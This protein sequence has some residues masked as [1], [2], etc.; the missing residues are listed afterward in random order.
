MDESM[1]ARE[2]RV[3]VE[4]YLDLRKRGHSRDTAAV[5]LSAST[6]FPLLTTA[7][8]GGK[9][10]VC[11]SNLDNWKR[12]LRG[13]HS[14]RRCWYHRSTI[15]LPGGGTF[16]SAFFCLYM[17]P[18][19]LSTMEA[20]RSAATLARPGEVPTLQQCKHVVTKRVD[21]VLKAL[22]R[23]ETLPGIQVDTEPPAETSHG[24]RNCSRKGG[25]DQ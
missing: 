23:G 25:P 21:P 24:R 14:L 15:S 9:S 2:K 17:K 19:R 16:W 13:G 12:R 1:L 3:A 6:A 10:A 22:C 4:R 5:L 7:G 18:N 11:V 8:R 20:Y